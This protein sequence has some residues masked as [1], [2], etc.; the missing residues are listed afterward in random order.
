MCVALCS[1]ITL[2]MVRL[3]ERGP[4]PMHFSAGFKL[5]PVSLRAGSLYSQDQVTVPA[6]PRLGGAVL[7]GRPSEFP[8]GAI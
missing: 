2:E 4:K 5:P 1:P 6:D 3:G 7:L 8:A